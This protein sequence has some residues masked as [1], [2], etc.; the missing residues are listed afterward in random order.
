LTTKLLSC[1]KKKNAL[2]TKTIRDILSLEF[3]NAVELG[4]SNSKTLG[5]LPQKAF[6]KYAEQGQLIGAFENKT[7]NIQGYILYR[8]SYNRVTIV[9]LCVNKENRNNGTAKKLFDYLKNTTKHFDGIRLSCRNDYNIDSF[10]QKLGFVPKKEKIGRSKQQLPL[11]IWW[12]PHSQ[13]DLFSQ[14]SEYEINNKIVAVIDMNIFLDIKNKRHEESLALKSDW[15]VSEAILYC[16]R[17][18]NNEINNGKTKEDRETS[19]DLLKN[20]N[21]LPLNNEI[22]FQEVL[23]ELINEFPVD[24]ENDKSDLRHIAYSISEGA[25]FFITRDSILLKRKKLFKN[26][27]LTIY[28]PSE[29]ITHLD[30]HTHVSKYE[31]QILIGTDI[32]SRRVNS[33]NIETYI[34]TFLQPYEKKSHFKKIVLKSLSNPQKNEIITISKNNILLA[35]IIFNRDFDSKLSIPVFRFLN[36]PLKSTL[37]KHI[38]FKTLFLTTEENRSKIEITDRQLDNDLKISIQ[39]S[40]FIQ[41]ENTWIKESINQILSV[42]DF[43]SKF[44]LNKNLKH[45]ITEIDKNSENQSIKEY[46]YERFFSPLKISDLDIPTYIVPIKPY[47]AQ[48]LFNDKSKEQLALFEPEYELLLNRENVYYRSSMPRVLK[49]PSR[50]LWY[51]SENKTTKQSGSIIASSYIDEVFV[52]SPK[53]LF[54]QFQKLGIY[55]WKDISN[56]AKSKKEIMAFIFSDTE[57][58]RN[59]ISIE[60]TKKIFSEYE[61]KKFM[62][63]APLKINIETYIRIYKEGLSK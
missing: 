62:I 54:K 9:H 11:T 37:S 18:I 34:N 20:F 1:R 25:R 48:Q 38:L 32:N 63:V 5:F 28:T 39:E 29:F 35:L 24:S 17:E 15:L 44:S 12:Y 41:F 26:Y 42:S 58:F 22:K 57:L 61:N 45:I 46:N 19:R 14:V 59:S 30:E 6:E 40:R 56:T 13:N 53:K 4:D 43:N 33:E 10:W 16:T 50:I 8:I 21:I 7:N 23:N 2:K 47:W 27:N 55:K 31:P 49:S 36:S 52:D 60:K 51:L 3:K